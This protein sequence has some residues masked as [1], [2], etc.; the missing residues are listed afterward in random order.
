M[1]L[2]HMVQRMVCLYL[3]LQNVQNGTAWDSTE[4]YPVCV[5]ACPMVC[6]EGQATRGRKHCLWPELGP[7]LRSLTLRSLP[8]L[9]LNTFFEEQTWWMLVSG[10]LNFFKEVSQNWHF[11]NSIEVQICM[12]RA[13]WY[14][15]LCWSQHFLSTTS[16][17][18]RFLLSLFDFETDIQT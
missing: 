18:N 1:V 3:L 15:L 17:I 16:T 4:I 10:L 11:D 9:C 5:V 7:E 6:L 13:Y 2:S 12:S 8:S 14:K